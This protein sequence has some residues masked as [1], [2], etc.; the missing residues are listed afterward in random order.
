M[1]VPSA[2]HF[3]RVW[4]QMPANEQR[5]LQCRE[6]LKRAGA[7]DET[8]HTEAASPSPEPRDTKSCCPDI[9]GATLQR[10]KVQHMM[11]DLHRL[12]NLDYYI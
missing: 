2:S 10:T 9:A 1:C 4:S 8:P 7:L 5:K 11:I 3:E 6:P 12:S